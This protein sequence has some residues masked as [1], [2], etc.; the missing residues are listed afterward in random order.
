MTASPEMPIAK[1]VRQTRV[2]HDTEMERLELA[3]QQHC[4]DR[5]KKGTR[6]EHRR[7]HGGTHYSNTY[8][9]NPS[10]GGPQA[11]RQES[12]QVPY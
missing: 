7:I 12:A 8:S 6:Q 4:E 1:R 5:H 10:A 3:I 2:D 9:E 11:K